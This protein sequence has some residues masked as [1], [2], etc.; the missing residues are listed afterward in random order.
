MAVEADIE[1][2]ELAVSREVEA[3]HFL[4]AMAERVASN[5]IRTLLEELA[6]EE[7]EHKST[8]ELEM[9][10]LGHTVPIDQELPG[11]KNVRPTMTC[12][13]VLNRGRRGVH[14]LADGHLSR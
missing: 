13:R 9:M 4:M 11:P 1:I 12:T 2:L 10:K 14:S 3:Y 8:L 6:T 5:A 7:L